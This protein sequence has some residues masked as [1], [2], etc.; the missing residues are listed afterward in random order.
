MS[1][2]ALRLTAVLGIAILAAGCAIAGVNRSEEDT[3]AT[4]SVRPLPPDAALTARA[5]SG[6]VSCVVDEED[7]P[8]QMLIQDR[9]TQLSA[10]FLFAGRTQFGDCFVTMGSGASGGSSGPLPGP[11]TAALVIDANDAGVLGSGKVSLLGGRVVNGAG[12]VLIE[13]ADGRSVIESIGN[14]YWLTWWPDTT[15]ARRVVARD[16]AGAE[17]ATVDAAPVEVGQ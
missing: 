12:Q 16:A 7:G 9:R 10:A 13:L 4:W 14:G 8:I 3:L 5:A 2:L 1:G 15:M 17:I 11:M 6:Q